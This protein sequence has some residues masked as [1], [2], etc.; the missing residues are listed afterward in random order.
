MVDTDGEEKPVMHAC[1]HDMHIAAL[2]GAASLLKAATPHWQGRLLAVFQPNEE[3]GGGARA[4]VEDGLYK[5][6]P[7]PDVVLGQHLVKNKA[8]TLQIGPGYVLAGKRTFKVTIYGRG[9]HSSSPQECIDPVVI[10][11]AVV[12]RLQTIVSREI[13]PQETTVV[14]CGSFH[15]GYSPNAIPDQAQLTVDVRGYSTEVLDKITGKKAVRRVTVAECA[16]SGAVEDPTIEEIEHVTPLHNDAGTVGPLKEQLNALLGG[17]AIQPMVPD[18][19]SDDFSILAPDGI[20]YAY[21]T[22]GSTPLDVW[23]RYESEGRLNEL[24]DTHS[25]L[26]APAIEPT[27][28]IGIDTLATAALAFLRLR[29]SE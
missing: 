27:L 24:P 9:G 28:R 23:D 25:P 18:M 29:D 21:W 6:V 17:D 26:F 8:G 5:V 2:M 14:T 16:A 7:L 15:A 22:L 19:A 13:D 4:M 10:A 1:G 12:M 3:R 11:C 20:P